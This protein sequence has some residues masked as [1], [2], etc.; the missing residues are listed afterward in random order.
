MNIDQRHIM[1]GDRVLAY[2]Y[3]SFKNDKDTPWHI[4][5]LPATVTRRYGLI[6]ITWQDVCYDDYGRQYGE[7][8]R[9]LYPDLVDLQF[10]HMDRESKGH[11][12]NGVSV[13]E[14]IR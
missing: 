2:D 12:T 10:D 3:F 5:M 6:Y 4:L 1:P 11:F 7:P 8:D 13:V 14:Y 9:W